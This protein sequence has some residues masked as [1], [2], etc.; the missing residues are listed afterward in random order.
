M[1]FDI[2]PERTESIKII[3]WKLPSP[4]YLLHCFICL[5]YF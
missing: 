1:S 5:I 4:F 3:F 2:I